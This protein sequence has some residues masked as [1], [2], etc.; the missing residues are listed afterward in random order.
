MEI[1]VIDNDGIRLDKFLMDR[2]NV[3]RSKMRT[4]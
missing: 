2:L 4:L 1:K 3:S